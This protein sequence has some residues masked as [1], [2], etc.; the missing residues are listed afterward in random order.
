MPSAENSDLP[1]ELKKN[2]LAV[3]REL[4]KPYMRR[5]VS[6]DMRPLL[7][8]IDCPV[9]AFNGTKDIQ[10]N[11]E[12]NLEALRKGLIPNSKH[13]INE[14]DGANHLMQSCTTGD[15]SEY[16]EIEQ[17]FDPTVLQT[18]VLWIKSFK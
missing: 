7:E 8:D 16:A 15:V 2:Y 6:L 14:V 1:E 13:S 18:I 5:F 4:D 17:T 11:Y 3:V 10:V 12:T 9:L